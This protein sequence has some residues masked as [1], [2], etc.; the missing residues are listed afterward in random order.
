MVR[1]PAKAPSRP[2][3]FL[4]F[5]F[6]VL[7]VS[8]GALGGTPSEGLENSGSASVAG[9]CESTTKQLVHEVASQ[10]GLVEAGISSLLASNGR[11]EWFSVT[12]GH[13]DHTVVYEPS[14][15]HEVQDRLEGT[16]TR[17]EELKWNGSSDGLG[18]FSAAAVIE[19][20]GGPM[21]GTAKGAVDCETGLLVT[22]SLAV[23]SES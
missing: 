13:N 3:G 9:D 1:P 8:C 19:S 6:A 10:L 7:L 14:D 16:T 15:I 22:F 5:V 11:F 17:L 12:L 4:A 2:A 23:D 21:H 20:T 18:H